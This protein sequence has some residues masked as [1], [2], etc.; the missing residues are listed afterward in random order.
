MEYKARLKANNTQMFVDHL[1]AIDV[2]DP[3]DRSSSRD[4]LRAM[5]IGYDS[6]PGVLGVPRYYPEEGSE[7]LLPINQ[8]DSNSA[9]KHQVHAFSDIKPKNIFDLAYKSIKYDYDGS[10]TTY[11]YF[12][13]K[14]TPQQMVD[15]RL[16]DIISRS[17]DKLEYFAG[18]KDSLSKAKHMIITK[19][20]V[21]YLE[22]IGGNTNVIIAEDDLEKYLEKSRETKNFYLFYLIDHLTDSLR[23][24]STRIATYL[25][26]YLESH[27]KESEDE[28]TMLIYSLLDP[29]S[30]NPH[31][32][33]IWT[34]LLRYLKLIED[35]NPE[36]FH[37]SIMMLIDLIVYNNKPNLLKELLTVYPDTILT[38]HDSMVDPEDTILTI[39]DTQ[40]T[41]EDHLFTTTSYEMFSTILD[42]MLEKMGYSLNSEFDYIQYYF[43]QQSKVNRSLSGDHYDIDDET[44]KNITRYRLYIFTE[45][46]FGKHLNL[47]ELPLM[48]L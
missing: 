17:L 31:L 39:E 29:D 32:D 1:S 44:E 21:I 40:L 27:L 8:P 2:V 24:G 16:D 34:V 45:R 12:L 48:Y 10:L 28:Y 5:T 47:K 30:I 7:R 26:N 6:K 33:D 37:E 23:S 20:P 3:K 15:T 19:V 13:R 43:D 25:F 22:K 14:I 18:S 46:Y 36:S 9:I 42:L 41:I 11:F 38:S 4:Y 35:N